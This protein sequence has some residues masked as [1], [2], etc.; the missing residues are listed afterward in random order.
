MSEFFAFLAECLQALVDE[1]EIDLADIHEIESA[2]GVDG[3]D[4][5][6]HLNNEQFAMM[7]MERGKVVVT[8]NA[9]YSDYDYLLKPYGP[10]L[11]ARGMFFSAMR[12]PEMRMLRAALWDLRWEH[13][14]DW[15]TLTKLEIDPYLADEQR[16]W[17]LITDRHLVFSHDPE[18][19]HPYFYVTRLHDENDP[20]CECEWCQ[21]S[22]ICHVGMKD[23][24][25][26]FADAYPVA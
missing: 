9:F 6:F 24:Y 15:R 3:K 11:T 23:Y 13:N 1:L 19:A 21:E 2:G 16:M 7:R 4:W 18:S 20:C 12:R 14:I 17:M 22:R 25:S 10:G 26:Q 5:T 8:F